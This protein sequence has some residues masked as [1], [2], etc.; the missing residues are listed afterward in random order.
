VRP[1]ALKPA[2]AKLV[3]E[4]FFGLH[5]LRLL[6]RQIGGHLIDPGRHPVSQSPFDRE[7][8]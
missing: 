1:A 5:P 6:N 3:G 2:A 4:P 8:G 7:V